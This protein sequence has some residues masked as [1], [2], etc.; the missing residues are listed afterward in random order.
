MR[1]PSPRWRRSRT[2]RANSGIGLVFHAAEIGRPCLRPRPGLRGA[3]RPRWRAR[4]P[5]RGATPPRNVPSGR[6][7]AVARRH[8]RETA[9]SK[10]HRRG[11]IAQSSRPGADD[12]AVL[13]CCA[14]VQPGGSEGR[15]RCG[16]ESIR[17][18][19]SPRRRRRLHGRRRPRRATASRPRSL[20]RRRSRLRSSPAPAEGRHDHEDGG[21]GCQGEG[22][23][24]HLH[25]TC[26][27]VHL[28]LIALGG[29]L[30]AGR[31]G[32]PEFQLRANPP[33]L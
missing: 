14:R 8:E 28:Q 11:V 29:G 18:P 23:P 12:G 26:E 1:W 22:H 5:G 20:R 9:A 13:M 30:V 3:A 25:A 31:Q 17:R 2:A 21:D 15:L 33:G 6:S 32:L 27:V 16:W 10:P 24:G 19:T 4:P 7:R